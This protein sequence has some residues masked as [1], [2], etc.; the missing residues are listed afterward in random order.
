MSEEV[1]ELLKGLGSLKQL[2]LGLISSVLWD[3]LPPSLHVLCLRGP[4][5][6]LGNLLQ[7]Q[8]TCGAVCKR[9]KPLRS[10]EELA[11]QGAECSRLPLEGK[12]D[13]FP[14][15]RPQRPSI[16]PLRILGC[17]V[18]LW[19]ASGKSQVPTPPSPFPSLG[20]YLC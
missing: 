12:A 2:S 5:E 10:L 20:R 8:S 11:I 13:L 16:P 14:A 15:L 1:G 6:G 19:G 4:I 18:P 9:V 3:S 7:Q 17:R